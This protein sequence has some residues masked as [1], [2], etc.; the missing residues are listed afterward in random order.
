MPETVNT[1]LAFVILVGL[2][3]LPLLLDLAVRLLRR[4]VRRQ[5][6]IGA[7]EAEIDEPIRAVKRARL[8]ISP[9]GRS[10]TL[11]GLTLG[12]R[13]DVEDDARCPRGCRQPADGCDCGFYALRPEVE[14]HV[15]RTGERM[16]RAT[17]VRLD[18][19]LSGAVL[20][21]ELGYRAQHQRVLRVAVP[22]ICA[23][24]A[25]FDDMKPATGLSAVPAAQHPYSVSV[26]SRSTPG[27]REPWATL[28]P[29]CDLHRR[30][31]REEP[32]VGL[33]DL[34]G[35]IGTEVVWESSPVTEPPAAR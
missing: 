34:A 19:E 11:S 35:M 17:T 16:Q 27:A 10:A 28:E 18:V 7:P 14:S 25:R 24:C 21:Y 12:G 22:T 2:A 32:A 5:R 9:D 26:L 20:E 31:R 4:R 13:Y 1:V 8:R 33:A 23:S 29:T 15:F 3:T 6:W 30:A